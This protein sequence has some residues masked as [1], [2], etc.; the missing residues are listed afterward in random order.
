MKKVV[1]GSAATMNADISSAQCA[2]A[3]WDETLNRCQR[4]KPEGRVMTAQ[5]EAKRKAG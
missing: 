1:I 5:P 2:P 3:R 4:T